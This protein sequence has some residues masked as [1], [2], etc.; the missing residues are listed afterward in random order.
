MTHEV[1]LLQ[2]ISFTM[3]AWF[4]LSLPYV[5]QLDLRANQLELAA[6]LSCVFMQHYF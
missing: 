4:Y 6:I 2:R 3:F 5:Y 1:P